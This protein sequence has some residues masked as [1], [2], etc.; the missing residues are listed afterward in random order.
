VK[1]KYKKILTNVCKERRG[2]KLRKEK[3]KG[4]KNK[5]RISK[6]CARLRRN[7]LET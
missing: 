7:R 3:C 6:I 5:E 4:K 1:Q 2:E